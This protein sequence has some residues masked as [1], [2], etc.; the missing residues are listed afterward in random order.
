VDGGAPF[1]GVLQAQPDSEAAVRRTATV[2]IPTEALVFFFCDRD[3]F[4]A[5]A[6]CVLLMPVL[7]PATAL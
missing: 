7:V 6:T 5:A 2:Q 4:V 1:L 3:R